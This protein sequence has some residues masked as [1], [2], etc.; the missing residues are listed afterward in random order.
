MTARNLS[1][2]L[3]TAAAAT[4]DGEPVSAGYWNWS[5][6]G[7]FG[8]A[9]AQLQW[10]PDSAAWIDVDGATATANGGVSD[11]PIAAGALRVTITGGSSI[12]LTSRVDGIA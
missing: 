2:T 8:G 3:L 1:V 12:S 11:I 6:W 9:T 4:G 5:V 7:T 10:S